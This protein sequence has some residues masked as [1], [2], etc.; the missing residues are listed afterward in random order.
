MAV[1]IGSNVAS[2]G[3]LRQLSK[4][5][6]ELSSVSSRLS[7]GLRITKAGDDAAGLAIAE[8]LRT[9]V[10]VYGQAVRNVNDGISALDI[11]E[12]AVRE[13]SFIAIRQNEL[14]EQAANGV[15]SVDQRRALDT[16]ANALV[17]EYNRIVQSTSFN[18]RALLDTTF[19]GVR[20]QAGYGVDGSIAIGIGD[21]LAR[22][23]GNGEFTEQS[24]FATAASLS[25]VLAVDINGDGSLD[26]TS[27]ADGVLNVS[28]GNGDGTFQARRSYGNGTFFA[29]PYTL[30]DVNND[31]FLDFV[32]ASSHAHIALGNGDGSFK[33]AVTYAGFS[34]TPSRVVA[35]DFD[36]DGRMDI[37]TQSWGGLIGAH[38]RLGNG[39]GTFKADVQYSSTGNNRDI[40]VG[41]LNGDGIVDFMLGLDNSGEIFLGN[42][43]G[44]FRNAGFTGSI[45]GNIAKNTLADV[46]GDGALD[47]ISTSEASQVHIA[48]GN[49]N[50]SFRAMV[51]YFGNGSH[52][53]VITADTNGDDILDILTVNNSGTPTLSVLIGNGNGTF[54]APWSTGVGAAP[55]DLYAGD[56]NGDGAIDVVTADSG[57]DVVRLFFGDTRGIATIETLDLLTSAAAREALT[58]TRSTLTRITTELGN[59]GSH[60]SR[61][62]VAAQN[63]LSSRENFSAA[64]SRITD[65]DLAEESAKLVRAQILQNSAVE[66]L[67][68]TNSLPETALRLL[69]G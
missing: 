6:A 29:V 50:G 24:T 12:G 11:A 23:A 68:R 21:G 48:L 1:V 47:F 52:E 35:A 60:Q 8:S 41:D 58:T 42:G 63:L 65:A 20:V 37:A 2:L 31:S 59:I 32:G 26:V 69:S 10:R 4:S 17:S 5:T 18:G 28:L 36:N 54:T 64:A 38:I 3:A 33:V 44:T 16:E 57:P 62:Q 66:V 39:N 45:P 55:A 19:S 53:Q 43:N 27:N 40:D 34:S 67:R 61:L 14:A 15:Y 46:N 13:L 25:R 22:L 7:S 51:S 49:G 56:F 9:D 30:A